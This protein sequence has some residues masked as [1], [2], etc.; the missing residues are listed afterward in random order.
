MSIPIDR[1]NDIFDPYNPITLY[2]NSTNTF[3][4]QNNSGSPIF[5]INTTTPRV[6]I[7]TSNFYINGVIYSG[8]G[9]YLPINSSVDMTGALN[10]GT[11]KV[12]NM[13]NPSN[14]SDAVTLS[15]MN[16]SLNE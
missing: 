11:N 16:S 7:Y 2:G 6:D 4:V 5:N 8:G 14:P 1:N 9:A 10:M 3:Q 15:Y 12:V 13:A